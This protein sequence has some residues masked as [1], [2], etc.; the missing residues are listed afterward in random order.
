MNDDTDVD[1]CI[2]DGTLDN[3]MFMQVALWMMDCDGTSRRKLFEFF[4]GQ[5]SINVNSWSGDSR[6]FSFV[7]YNIQRKR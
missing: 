7:S 5:G 2:G 6:Y 4:G 3:E 1:V